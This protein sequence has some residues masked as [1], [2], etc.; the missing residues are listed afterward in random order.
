MCT[1]RLIK[2]RSIR[3][4]DAPHV[5]ARRTAPSL[6]EPNWSFKEDFSG[7][8]RGAGWHIGLHRFGKSLCFYGSTL[9]V[10]VRVWEIWFDVCEEHLGLQTEMTSYLK[11]LHEWWGPVQILQIVRWKM[12]RSCTKSAS[13][14]YY[15]GGNREFSNTTIKVDL[16]VR[17][18]RLR[19]TVL[20]ELTGCCWF[21]SLCRHKGF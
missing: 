1:Y 16:F 13:H 20:T 15:K 18:C 4:P 9:C 12:G 5:G 7:S 10:C 6:L 2:G 14:K 3:A 8:T 17:L 19:F 11:A 21:Y